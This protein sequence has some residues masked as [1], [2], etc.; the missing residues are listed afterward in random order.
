M[1]ERERES[2][3]TSDDNEGEN[4]GRDDET[5]S[6]DGSR[7]S[8]VLTDGELAGFQF[9]MKATFC[10]KAANVSPLPPLVGVDAILLS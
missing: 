10:R 9:F 7:D 8:C 2:N 6:S 5:C 1:T 4:K 3:S